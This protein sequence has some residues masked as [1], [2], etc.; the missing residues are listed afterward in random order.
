MARLELDL[1]SHVRSRVAALQAHFPFRTHEAVEKMR[2][3]I[4]YKC[5]LSDPKDRAQC[6]ASCHADVQSEPTGSVEFS[7]A[8]Q[9]V[10]SHCRWVASDLYALA[11]TEL[12]IVRVPMINET[13]QKQFSSR[14]VSA[15]AQVRR[16]ERYQDVLTLCRSNVITPPSLPPFRLARVP[17]LHLDTDDVH[18]LIRDSRLGSSLASAVSQG[19]LSYSDICKVYKQFKV[20]LRSPKNKPR[21]PPVE[22]TGNKSQRRRAIYREHQ[23]L[24]ALGPRV[25]GDHLLLGGDSEAYTLPSLH[26]L[27]DT[28]FGGESRSM[29]TSLV[30]TVKLTVDEDLFTV[31]EVEHALKSLDD[32]AAPGPD[33]VTVKELKKI[34]LQ[35]LTLIMNNWWSYAVIP[36]ELKQSNTVFIP[37]CPKPDGPGDFRPLTISPVIVRLFSKLILRRLSEMSSTSTSRAFQMTVAHLPTCSYYRLLCGWP[38]DHPNHSLQSVWTCAKHL[39]RCRMLQ[40]LRLW[41]LGGFLLVRKR[42]LKRCTLTLLRHIGR[43]G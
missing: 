33:G 22:V 11:L 16:T 14:S 42:L 19:P 32:R 28:L 34:S 20:Q 26:S 4:R 40:S 29:N 24:H 12:K 39:I 15:I 6:A 21:P 41:M 2:R 23:R 7:P 35:A 38:R 27:Y 30:S 8:S 36:L 25:L 17:P 43:V 13:L 3:T 31:T 18:E 37:K 5:I 10:Y 9:P 1:P